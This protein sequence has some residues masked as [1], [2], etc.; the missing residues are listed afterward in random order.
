V[1]QLDLDLV[2]PVAY[3][4]LKPQRQLA[5]TCNYFYFDE[6][7]IYDPVIDIKSL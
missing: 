2:H 7:Y 1:A 3:A 6:K 4:K 5:Q